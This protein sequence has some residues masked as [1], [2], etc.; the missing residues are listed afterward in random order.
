[1]DEPDPDHGQPGDRR[2]RHQEA[3]GRPRPAQRQESGKGGGRTERGERERLDR[4][5]ELRGHHAVPVERGEEDSHRNHDDEDRQREEPG[6]FARAP[7]VRGTAPSAPCTPV[8]AARRWPPRARP[9]TTAAIGAAP[10]RIHT[11]AAHTV[12]AVTAAIGTLTAPTTAST[13]ARLVGRGPRTAKRRGSSGSVAPPMSGAS[14]NP[15]LIAEPPSTVT[16]TITS[17][18]TSSSVSSAQH[19]ATVATISRSRPVV[20]RATWRPSPRSAPTSS[21]SLSRRTCAATR[22]PPRR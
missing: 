14:A 3:R 4:L 22:D 10:C 13:A 5:G 2:D 7:L 11:M 8:P 16:A 1:M 17:V 12:S 20:T 18:S 9:P 21:A 6:Q 19:P 15:R